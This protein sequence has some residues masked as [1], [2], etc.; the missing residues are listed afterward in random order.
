MSPGDV[1][2]MFFRKR[3]TNPGISAAPLTSSPA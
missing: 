2:W 1:I 3:T